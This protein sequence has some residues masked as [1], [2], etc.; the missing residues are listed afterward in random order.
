M[1][2]LG[3][4]D[5]Y[6]N[7]FVA[8]VMPLMILV[9]LTGRGAAN[10]RNTYLWREHPNFM[11]L[12]MGIIGLLSIWSMIQLAGHFHL[13]SGEAVQAVMVVIGVP[14]LVLAFVEIWLGARL[15]VQYLRTRGSAA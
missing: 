14:F 11:W 7:L 6:L 2:P 10:P 13:I 3:T 8:V 1:Q 4:Y 15:L 9:N 12:S 5:L